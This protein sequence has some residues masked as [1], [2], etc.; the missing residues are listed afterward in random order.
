MKKVP[1]YIDT[2]GQILVKLEKLGFCPVLVGGMALV[3]LGSPRVTKD[4]D[5]LICT[6]GMD[7]KK[8]FEIFYKKGFALASKV[9]QHNNILT[10]INNQNI[11]VARVKID[12]PG[13][14]YFLN[15]KTGLRIDLLLDFP[16]PASEL[17]TRAKI[18]KIR[19][20]SFRVASTADIIKLKKISYKDRASAADA[21]D[22]EF[23]RKLK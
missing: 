6:E 15:P 10:T 22:L 4:F 1:D 23:L 16:L 7:Y 18:K 3:I 2:V 20:Y 19:S 11:A 21:A 17:V 9:D 12:A 8:L 14:I 13:S 5:F